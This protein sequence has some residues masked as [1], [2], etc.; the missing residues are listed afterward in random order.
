MEL[1]KSFKQDVT[2]KKKLE[3]SVDLLLRQQILDR[4]QKLFAQV[5]RG[6]CILDQGR[7]FGEIEK[8]HKEKVFTIFSFENYIYESQISSPIISQDP[9]IVR[10]IDDKIIIT[11]LGMRTLL[12]P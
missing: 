12:D 11:E 5:F 2:I 4:V 8:D 7:D 1:P 3:F 9:R 10:C 6:S